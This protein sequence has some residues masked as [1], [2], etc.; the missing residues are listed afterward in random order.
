MEDNKI[1]CPVCGSELK[2]THR[3]NYED[4][5]DHVSWDD[6]TPCLKDGYQCINNECL[7][8]EYGLTWLIDGELYVR[9]DFFPP[10]VTYSMVNNRIKELC[11]NG[12]THAKNSW[13]YYYE[14]GNKAVNKRTLHI[15][16]FKLKIDVIPKTYGYKYPNHK[17]DMPRLIGWKFEYW[18]KCDENTY[19]NIIPINRMVKYNIDTFNSAYL[20]LNRS[21]FPLNMKSDINDAAN[22]IKC[23]D[24]F[25]KKDNRKYAKISSWIVNTFY[26]QKSKYI[27]E[28]HQELN[29]K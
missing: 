22:I 20:R 17:R 15:N 10:D 26:K 18:K 2:V 14:K 27:L 25:G 12:N 4:I 5:Q 23:F 13:N 16:I 7:A 8:H 3:D 28:L 9:R 24:Y 21:N 11:E 1:Y 6:S 29:N 19:S